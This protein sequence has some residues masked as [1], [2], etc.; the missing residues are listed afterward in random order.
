ME[1][2][3]ERVEITYRA[4]IGPEGGRLVKVWENAGD[5]WVKRR[6]MA[7]GILI[8]V[9]LIGLVVWRIRRRR[10]LATLNS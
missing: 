8:P 3:R 9:G 7:A 4:E 2:D 6:W 5:P 1:P 10:N